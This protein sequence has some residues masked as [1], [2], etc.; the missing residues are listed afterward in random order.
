MLDLALIILY[1]LL[2]IMTFRIITV[3]KSILFYK[4]VATYLEDR[5]LSGFCYKLAL[6]RITN[7]FF[8]DHCSL[9]IILV[10]Y[11]RTGYITVVL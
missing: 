7:H 3:L 11:L 5:R 6:V 1:I 2:L 9:H 8:S 4:M 10:N